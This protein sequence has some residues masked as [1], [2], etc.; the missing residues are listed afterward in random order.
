VTLRE[1]LL[2]N[3]KRLGINNEQLSEATGLPKSTIDKIT[4][5]T[6]TDPKLSTLTALAKYFGC[7]ID[8]LSDI[9]QKNAPAPEDA[10]DNW[11][12]AAADQLYNML[13][14]IGWVKQ[15]EKTTVQQREILAAT[16]QLLKA[17][18]HSGDK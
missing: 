8:D 1:V 12:V 15:G 17:Q 18:F 2:Q 11:E 3:K 10:G 6:T 14:E 5:G 9:Q 13:V 4:A 7:T 16:V